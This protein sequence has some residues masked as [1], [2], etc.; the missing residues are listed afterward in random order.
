MK[1]E[2][3]DDAFILLVMVWEGNDKDIVN[4]A[5]RLKQFVSILDDCFRYHFEFSLDSLQLFQVVAVVGNKN[6]S[7]VTIVF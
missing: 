4:K 3:F 2:G 6:F 5:G 1:N 7:A